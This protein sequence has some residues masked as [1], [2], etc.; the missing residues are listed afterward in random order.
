MNLLGGNAYSKLSGC[1]SWNFDLKRL[2]RNSPASSSSLIGQ[3]DPRADQVRYVVPM[4]VNDA[5]LQFNPPAKPI[6][7]A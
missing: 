1:L 5:G 4:H 6:W 3:G 2:N 7:H